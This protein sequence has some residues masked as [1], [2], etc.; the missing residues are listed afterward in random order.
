MMSVQDEFAQK[1]IELGQREATFA[2]GRFES[3]ERTEKHLID[4]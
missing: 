1:D 3:R 4:R 2:S